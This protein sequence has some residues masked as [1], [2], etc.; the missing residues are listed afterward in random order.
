[1]AT[2]DDKVNTGALATLVAVGASAMIGISLGVNAL[3]RHE[4]GTIGAMRDEVG[5]DAYRG[6]KKAQLEALEAPAARVD[7]GKGEVSIPI[8][9]AMKLVLTDLKRSPWNA[10]P[11]PPLDAGTDAA[12]ETPDAGAD[13]APTA[14][15]DAGG[16]G[17]GAVPEPPAPAPL[18]PVAPKPSARPSSP[19]P[20]VP[21]APRHPATPH[22]QPAPHGQ[23]APPQ[24][25]ARP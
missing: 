3:V 2:E 20:T 6:L 5:A 19:R 14:E 25:P 24:P 8:E 4:A 10:T 15:V 21:A 12:A 11:A 13:A 16:A 18:S 9:R 23:P 1:M 17:T 22:R 7:G